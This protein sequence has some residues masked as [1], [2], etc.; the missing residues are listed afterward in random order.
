MAVIQKRELADGRTRWTMRV[1]VGRDVKGKRKFVVRTFDRKKDADAEARRLERMKDQGALTEPSKESLA[2]YLGRWLDAKEGKVRARTIFDYRSLVKRYVQEPA[3]DAPPIGS[4]RM[5]RLTP[6]AFEALY[7]YLRDKGLSPRTIQYLHAVL[8]QALKA[9]V[10]K[11]AIPSNPTDHAERPEY[12]KGTGGDAVA[13]KAVRALNQEQAGRFLEAARS[14]RYHALWVL[15]LECGVRPGEALGLG[16]PEVDLDGGK[17]HIRRALTRTGIPKLCECGH[18]HDGEDHEGDC[19]DSTCRCQGFVGAPRWKL[20]PPKTDKSRRVVPL[21]V[22][23]IQ[24]L[25]EWRAVQ[26]RERL[27][28]GSEYQDHGLVFTTPFGSPLDQG[29]L[30]NFNFRRVMAAAELGEWQ[31]RDGRKWI[32]A[33]NVEDAEDRKTRF[34]PAHRIYDLRH[35]CATLLLLKSINPKVVQERLGH[36]SITL[37]LDTYSHVLPEMQEDA[38]EAMNAMFGTGT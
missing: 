24:A 33:A 3:D 35:T 25:R 17:V 18:E 34:R 38:T 32:P 29:N 7:T 27:L 20:V 4:I 14:D 11:R 37:T 10:R 23:T 16:W 30:T 13:R 5:D 15:L 22:R 36:A 8:R 19:T 6:E 1:F 12:A 9:A 28:L 26:A 2:A 21:P 31:V